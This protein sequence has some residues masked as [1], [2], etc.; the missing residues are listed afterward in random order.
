MKTICMVFVLILHT[1]HAAF[2]QGLS[3]AILVDIAQEI[4]EMRPFWS[5]FGYDEPNYTYMKDGQKL[6]TEIAQLSPAPVFVRT[7]NLLTT[8]VN[9]GPAGRI[10]PMTTKSG[11]NWFING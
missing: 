8:K 2:S 7:H 5:Y 6:L 9:F 4:G 1:T 3:T 11:R 10:H